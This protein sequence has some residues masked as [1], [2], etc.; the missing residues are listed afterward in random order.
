VSNSKKRAERPSVSTQRAR[1][2]AAGRRGYA[3]SPHRSDTGTRRKVTFGIV[4][5]GLLIAVWVLVSSMGVGQNTTANSAAQGTTAQ[6][7]P[8]VDAASLDAAI[9]ALMQ[10]AQQNPTDLTTQVDLGNRFYDAQ[11]YTEAIPWYEKAI[12]QVPNNTDIRT[13]LGTSYFYTG[14]FDKAK[15]NWFKALEQ[16]PNKVETHFNL[17]VLY[18]HSTPPDMDSAVKEWETVVRI[19]PDSEQGKS[20][21]QKLK[22]AK[23]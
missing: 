6:S 3:P 17:A 12:Q 21:A 22:D 14:N 8:T 10:K 23:K 20:A 7:Q 15:E 11:R 16:D 1:P 18:T 5:G 2:T 9:A 19:A 4:V 13:D